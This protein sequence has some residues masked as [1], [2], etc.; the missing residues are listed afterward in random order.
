MPQPTD[1]SVIV[2]GVPTPLYG[3]KLTYL[4]AIRMAGMDAKRIP[5]VTYEN[6]ERGTDGFYGDRHGTLWHG[7]SITVRPEETIVNV[8][9]TAEPHAC[10]GY[11]DACG[12]CPYTYT[13]T[14]DE[15]VA[16]P[17]PINR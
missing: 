10:G 9:Y 2:N 15:L 8:A 1:V 12:G 13:P 6:A 16:Y 7:Q 3:T 14:E 11:C 5:T 17:E 4:N